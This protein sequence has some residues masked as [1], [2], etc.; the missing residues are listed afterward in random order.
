MFWYTRDTVA[1]EAELVLGMGV[2][3]LP[4]GAKRRIGEDV[5]WAGRRGNAVARRQ[6]VRRGSHASSRGVTSTQSQR[7]S[8]EGR[9]L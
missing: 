5:L 3:T 2:T 6:E 7:W 9:C 8:A 1:G 4:L